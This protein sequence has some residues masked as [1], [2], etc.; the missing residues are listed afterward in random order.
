MPLPTTQ[1]LFID[2]S[3]GL[4]YAT[5]SS[6]SPISNPSF[7]L[8]DMAKLRIYFIEQTGLGTYP[9]Q[10]VAGLGTPGIKVA[11]GAIDASPTAGHFHLTFGGDSTP[12]QAFNVTAA[13]LAADLNA[14]ASI[15]AAGGVTVTKIGDNYSIKFVS[16][17]SRGAF[18]G[19]GLALIP[20]STVGI[21]VLQEG[22]ASTPEIVLVHLQQNVAA[23]ATSFTAITP[24][25]I[26]TSVLSAWDGARAT[27]RAIIS[28]DPKAGTF[29]LGFDADTG[30]DVST[31]AIAVGSTALE[32]QNAL[33]K[34]A[35]LDKV[36]VQ[37][38]GAYAYDITVTAE[39]GAGGLTG[40]SAGLLS[41]AGFEGD[42]DI[43][44]ANAI[45]YLDGAESITTTLEVEIAD[46]TDTQTILQIPCTLRSSVVDETTVNAVTLDPVLT[47][48]TGDGRYLRQANDLSDVT[49][50]V[51]ARANLDVYSIAETDA[52][53]AA[54]GGGGGSFLPLSGGTMTGAITFDAVGLQNITKGTFDNSTGGYNG[55]SLICAVGYELNWQGGHLSNWYSGSF[56]PITLD[57]PLNIT[58][59][60][61][62]T[63]SDA[64]VQ[65]IAFPGFADYAPL[66]SPSFTSGI[67]VDGGVTVLSPSTN[68]TFTYSGL[69]LGGSSGGI[70]FAD[71]TVQTTAAVAGANF[72]DIFAIANVKGS[73][74]T[75]TSP[76]PGEWTITFKPVSAY[77]ASAATIYVENADGSISQDA[78]GAV[79]TT[80]DWTYTTTYD[81]FPADVYIYIKFNG[82]KGTIPI[83]Y[84]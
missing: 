57:S 63:F 60:G 73:A 44:T 81:T 62:I 74:F 24:S 46:G 55:I 40:G 20:L 75:G 43:N 37:Q 27:Y 33:S 61:G 9:R 12:N 36:S 34:D 59:A 53:I 76:S 41:F 80:A 16:N 70:T 68:A 29:T 7:F 39:P 4:A 82:I 64:S 30:T 83:N 77:I 38:V 14:L 67:T 51:T 79:S 5:Y 49:S 72:G 13:A 78:K 8:G 2:V 47:E 23:L 56:Q 71:A 6:T 45:S 84:P 1:S 10:E 11:V 69:D 17:G 26:S 3:A 48:A 35:L 25:T 65:T 21:S 50:V 54:G 19:N 15:I 28:P 31:S 18:T 58:D 66:I 32:V 52:A 22:D 42:L